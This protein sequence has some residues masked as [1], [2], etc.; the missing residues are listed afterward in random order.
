MEQNMIKFDDEEKKELFALFCASTT[1]ELQKV[2]T[3]SDDNYYS[4]E[5]LEEEYN[6]SLPKKE[7]AHDIWR[8]VIYY[9]NKHDYKLE[10]DGKIIDLSEFAQKL[11]IKI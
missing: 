4:N 11:F 10:K 3:S 8:S 1:Y 7:I 2:Y 9:L 6:L 5:K